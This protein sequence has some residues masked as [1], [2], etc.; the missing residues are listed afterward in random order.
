MVLKEMLAIRYALE[1]QNVP[2]D[3]IRD[4]IRARIDIERAA[5]AKAAKHA[6]NQRE[7]AKAK[8]LAAAHT[9]KYVCPQERADSAALE[10]KPIQRGLIMPVGAE[11]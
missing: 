11:W 6:H 2:D 7:I 5:K 8:Q 4:V 10:P 1:E 3:V 9:A